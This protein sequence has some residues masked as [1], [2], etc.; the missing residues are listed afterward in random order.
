MRHEN[1]IVLIAI[2][3]EQSIIFSS[4]SVVIIGSRKKDW[5]QIVDTYMI[6]NGSKG[7]HTPFAG[8]PGLITLVF[9]CKEQ[10]VLL[11]FAG[12][13]S[14]SEERRVGK[15]CVITCRYRCS[16]NHYKKKN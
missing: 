12:N 2:W 4:L 16:P 15:E 5:Q 14:S 9:S 3:R 6:R 7:Y 13:H 1:K 11:F 10:H 8:N